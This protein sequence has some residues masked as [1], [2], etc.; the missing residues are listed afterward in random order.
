MKQRIL[1]KAALLKL[2]VCI[3]FFYFQSMQTVMSQYSSPHLKT[4]GNRT[5]LIVEG[6]PF[7]SLAGELHNSSSSSLEYMEK[8]WPIL[9]QLN[10]NT[11]LAPVSW[12]L[13]EPVE[14]Q[15]D[16]SLVDG[17]IAQARKNNV[18]LVFLWFGSW[19]NLVSTYAP[20]WVKNNPKR[21][22]LYY[23]E[24]GERYQMLSSFSEESRDADA[25]AY[26]ALMKYIKQTDTKEQ[27]VIMMQVENEVGTSFGDRDC[28]KLAA[29]AYESQ[30]PDR[31]MAY[32]QKNKS[33]LIPEFKQLWAENGSK[34]K[35]S[36]KEI[37][38]EGALC[39]EIFMSWYLADY[40]GKVIEAGKAEYNIPMF[41]NA[42]VGRQTLKPATYPSGGPIPF[43]MDVWHAAAPELDM[44][45]PDIYY[46][47][48]DKICEQ[49]TLSGN[50]L[51]IP[52]TRAGIS[53]AANA[54]KT[55]CNFNSIGFSP[56]GIERY[57]ENT[58]DNSLF[59]QTYDIL[60][61]L[62]TLILDK[63]PQKQMIAISLDTIQEGNTVLG[64]YKI[65][66]KRQGDGLGFA[67]IIETNPD[68]FIVAGHNINIEFS[69]N[70][71]RKEEVIGIQFAEE[72]TFENG[73]WI[74]ER[75]MNGDQIMVNYS[76]ADLYKDGK[77]GNGLK[78]RHLSVQRV[79]LYT[80]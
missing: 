78:F 43:V 47:D 77:S 20:G 25:R 48:F 63:E 54:M 71:R 76:F 53:G 21:F 72:G 12:E 70:N 3:L 34:T 19:K 37:F 32:L 61:R 29:K 50:P 57:S 60:N 23:N 27:T 15:Y 14:G 44:L 35:G 51:Y 31:L 69:L 1:T 80:Y 6:Q 26:A 22:P 9:Q 4:V 55:F 52:E 45:C 24:D 65:D 28:S 8:L 38:G 30:V 18:K 42:S 75:R 2:I 36:W 5:Q 64:K 56:F 39:N 79:G 40:I 33:N 58:P 74:P 59:A 11:V 41:V 73:K 17:L 49:Y 68:E 62:S 67:M 66:C 46:G 13:V 7:L 16:F 10:L